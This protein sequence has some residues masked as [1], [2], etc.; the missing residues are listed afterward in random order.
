MKLPQSYCMEEA[1]KLFNKYTYS[2]DIIC[3]NP[4]YTV[5]FMPYYNGGDK[6]KVDSEAI[7]AFGLGDE[8]KVRTVVFSNHS[9]VEQKV[10]LNGT[11]L[12]PEWLYGGD[13]NDI[14]PDWMRNKRYTNWT[15]SPLNIYSADEMIAPTVYDANTPVAEQITIPPYSIMVCE[16]AE[17]DAEVDTS[18]VGDKA[19]KMIEYKMRNSIVMKI[20]NSTAYVDRRVKQIDEDN[21]IAPQIVGERTLLPLRF[22]SENFGC[23]V[24]F[25]DN[26]REITVNGDNVEIKMTL[27]Q[28][29]YVVNG[30]KKELDVVPDII[31]GRTFVPIRALGEALGKT[32]HW[33]N[34]IVFLSNYDK[35][36]EDL[37][38]GFSEQL[39]LLYQ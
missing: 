30:E 33:V 21:A 12:K 6:R 32:V 19:S 4:D 39:Y 8:E 26:T 20:N 17:G 34:G 3:T 31:G 38:E 11:K 27:G 7:V 10:S 37:D 23:E 1:G 36:C 9:D 14:M 16:I 18:Y 25:D 24:L 5:G 29:Q 28:K 2:Y 22:V 35:F 15:V 13:T